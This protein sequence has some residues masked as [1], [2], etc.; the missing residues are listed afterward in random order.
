MHWQ[1]DSSNKAQ[2]ITM[3]SHCTSPYQD[4]PKRR[5]MTHDQC[6]ILEPYYAKND[7]PTWD[8]IES[9]AEAIDM[10]VVKVLN[11]FNNRRAKEARLQR[12]SSLTLSQCNMNI[13]GTT[14]TTDANDD[15]DDEYE[16]SD[17]LDQRGLN[18]ETSAC[19]ATMHEMSP[20]EVDTQFTE[21]EAARACVLSM[22]KM[23]PEEVN[24]A[25]VLSNLKRRII[26]HPPKK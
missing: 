13:D 6:N 19:V 17:A 11:W 7:R 2:V 14:D 9:L 25:F 3:R 20:E 23:T 15:D 10:P 8:N 26:V 18:Q 5:H 1:A 4:A 24:A 12:E 16:S 22:A 21:R